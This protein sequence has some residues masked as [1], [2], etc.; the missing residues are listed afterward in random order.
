L[1]K[2]GG[3]QERE[4]REKMAAIYQLPFS[5]L[6]KKQLQILYLFLSIIEEDILLSEDEIYEKIAKLNHWKENNLTLDDLKTALRDLCRYNIIYSQEDKTEYGIRSISY[7]VFL[8]EADFLGLDPE[9]RRCLRDEIIQLCQQLEKALCKDQNINIIKPIIK[10][11]EE[12]CNSCSTFQSNKNYYFSRAARYSSN[13]E[14]LT[15]LRDFGCDI[16]APNSSNITPFAYAVRYNSEVKILDWFASNEAALEYDHFDGITIMHQ[17]AQFNSEL[18]ILQWL[19]EKGFKI[20]E[21]T[22]HGT[23][24]FEFAIVHNQSTAVLDFFYENKICIN[25][26]LPIIAKDILIKEIENVKSFINNNKN[27]VELNNDTFEIIKNEDESYFNELLDTSPLN[28]TFLLAIYN[29]NIEVFRWMLDHNAD[30]K[31]LWFSLALIV[32]NTEY[33]NLLFQYDKNLNDSHQEKNILFFTLVN[34]NTTALE[35]IIKKDPNLIYDT[36]FHDAIDCKNVSSLIWLFEN[37]PEPQIFELLNN[38]DVNGQTVF[39]YAVRNSNIDI[40][41]KLYEYIPQPQR[42]KLIKCKDKEGL[43]VFHWAI[44]KPVFEWLFNNVPK[45]QKLLRCRDK[46]GWTVF[47]CAIQ[48]SNTDVLDW[49]LKNIKQPQKLLKCKDKDGLTVFHYAARN[50]NAD[51]LGWL[52]KNVLQSQKLIRHKGRYGRTVFHYAVQ[53]SNTD[54]FEWLLKNIKQPQKLLR[55]RNKEGWTVFHDIVLFGKIIYLENIFQYEHYIDINKKI[56]SKYTALNM[57]IQ[58]N[59]KNILRSLLYKN[60]ELNRYKIDIASLYIND[61]E[62]KYKLLCLKAKKINRWA[63]IDI[64]PL[65]E[66]VVCN[67]DENILKFLLSM[68]YPPDASNKLG[69]TPLMAAALN[70]NPKMAITLLEYGADLEIRDCNGR[71]ALSYIQEHEQCALILEKAAAC[72]GKHKKPDNDLIKKRIFDSLSKKSKSILLDLIKL[73]G[74]INTELEK[75]EKDS[76]KRLFMKKIKTNRKAFNELIRNGI[77]TDKYFNGG[78]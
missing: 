18:K 52:F 61:D 30:T 49:L 53:N 25:T 36:I 29:P 67:D 66:A 43:T 32:R 48:D 69:Q 57:A 17:A 59:D 3:G 54:V 19:L 76:G 68:G 8:F 60:A 73:R 27:L 78:K 37:I 26:E 45:P 16:K 38:K 22:K 63:K 75:S 46:D 6:D 62:Y 20:N 10:K 13:P 1:E 58:N 4:I 39:H 9:S 56:Y 72:G 71:T 42:L 23:T 5:L 55:C 21:K 7:D 77:I 65:M 15:L 33:F 34:A 70:P 41:E 74:N 50:C 28:S 11:M 40:L 2:R 35:W 64:F 31:G 44:Q 51:T 24:P 47:H 12:K 14:I